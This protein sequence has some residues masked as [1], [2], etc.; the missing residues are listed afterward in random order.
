MKRREFLNTTSL[1]LAS[2]TLPISVNSFSGKINRPFSIGLIADLHHDLIPDGEKR[3]Q[4]FVNESRNINP[5]LIVQL[6]DFAFPKEENRNI[7]ELFNN[8]HQHCLHVIGNHDTDNGH[9]YEDLQKQW[10]ISAPYYSKEISGFLIIVLDGNEKG[11]PEHKGGYPAFIGKE[12]VSWLRSE[13]SNA[14][15]PVIIF[16]HQPLAGVLAVDNAKAIQKLLS[17]FQEKIILAI[18]GHT[19]IDQLLKVNGVNYFH[20]NSASYYWVGGDYKHKSYS[21][22][23]H[24]E[25]KWLEYTCPYQK[26]LFTFLTIDIGSNQIEISERISDWLGSSPSELTFQHQDLNVG[27]EIV[28]WI[29]EREIYS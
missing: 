24:E 23:V 10:R 11:S 17:Q 9:T 3:L 15:Q 14:D 18:N 4:E 6:G 27:E 20:V 19:H 28:P 2:F 8:S 16:S 25:Y 29:R 22:E 13:L 1:A 5:D 12:Q 26:S 21:D 7:I